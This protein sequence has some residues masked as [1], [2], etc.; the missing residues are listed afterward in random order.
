MVEAHLQPHLLFTP[1][2]KA[3]SPLKRTAGS[4]SREVRISWYQLFSFLSILVGWNPPPPKKSENG[5]RSLG[6]PQTDRLFRCPRGQAALLL[7]VAGAGVVAPGHHEVSAVAV[8]RQRAPH[9]RP[10]EQHFVENRVSPSNKNKQG[11]GFSTKR[12]FLVLFGVL[13]QQN[14]VTFRV[15]INT[16]TCLPE[17]MLPCSWDGSLLAL[18]CCVDSGS[19]VQHYSIY[20]VR[21]ANNIA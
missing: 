12:C 15:R 19:S 2:A 5:H 7:Q 18:I 21:R 14:T 13:V 1:Q 9:G 3:G 11:V 8:A 16:Q 20:P 6:V 17:P 4:S 10:N